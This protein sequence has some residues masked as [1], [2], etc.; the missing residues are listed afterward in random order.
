MTTEEYK[1]LSA[2]SEETEQIHL[3]VWCRW[4][5]SKYPELETIYH[6][7]NEGKRSERYGSL[8]KKMGLKPGVPDIHLPVARGKYSGLYI[9]LKKVGGKPTD[10]Q[11][12]WLELLERYGNCVAVCEGAERAEQVISAYCGRDSD[13]LDKLILSSERGD[14][15]KL[16]AKRP[17]KSKR[18]GINITYISAVISQLAIMAADVAANGAITGRSLIIAVGLSAAGLLTM[19]RGEEK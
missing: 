4:A 3:M 1:K 14:F 2:P 8:L 10:N 6:V 18:I 9:E 7:P 11:L 12:Y 19:A 17:S 13:T 15:D 16:R 5:Q